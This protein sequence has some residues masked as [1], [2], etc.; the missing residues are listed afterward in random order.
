MIKSAIV[1]NQKGIHA[2]TAAMIASYTYELKKTLSFDMFVLTASGRKIPI[3][4]AVQIASLSIRTGNAIQLEA[5][6]SDAQ[7]A[8]DLIC[9][10]IEK[11]IDSKIITL[12]EI[13]RVLDDNILRINREMT[14]LNQIKNQLS[15]I[16]DNLTDGIC[17]MDSE[18]MI[19][20]LNPAYEEIFNV[21]QA[22]VLNRDARELF[23]SRPSV[24]ALQKKAPSLKEIFEVEGR[25]VISNSIPIINEEGF[26][27]I[28][29]SYAQVD[30]IK[31]L[32]KQLEIAEEQANYYKKQLEQ[33]DNIHEA[34]EIL[35]GESDSLKSVLTTSSKAAKTSATVVIRGE[36]GTG[37]ELVAKSIHQASKRSE[38]PLIKINC[39]AFP[40]NLIESE[41]FGYEKG[42][43]T[44]ANDRKIGKFELAD[45]GTLFLDEIGELSQNVQ[46]KLLRF[47]QEREFRRIG[48]NEL[49]KVNVRIIA[50]TNRNL[51]DM[52]DHGSF[53]EDLYYRLSVIQVY[54]PPLRDRLSDIPLL[55]EYFIEKMA[56]REE[57]DI[58]TL[59]R[60]VLDIFYSYQWP[61]N[62]RELENVMMR[63]MTMSD[64]DTIDI[65]MLPRHMRGVESLEPKSLINVYDNEFET[66]ETYDREIIKRAL[67]TYGSYNK[68]AKALGLTHRTISLKAKKYGLSH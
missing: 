10:Y 61:G 55:A 12:D 60:A 21:K 65:G 24:K 43:F 28:I 52:M 47:L 42:A 57:M 19:E 54:V 29:T 2:R 34:F 58:K 46:V 1:M 7:V 44:G 62:I 3:S 33:Q 64:T 30:A 31:T 20:Y 17:L 59:S 50:A 40:E 4:H 18:G 9:R 16:L 45:G 22:D 32:L 67:Q 41:L 48:G 8:L 26:Q 39:A 14:T 56:K 68:T 51:E 5:T 66:M 15:T 37:K 13:D 25:N 38:G 27:G 11:E 35:I 36:S 6:G 63:G 49:I 23:P 53:R